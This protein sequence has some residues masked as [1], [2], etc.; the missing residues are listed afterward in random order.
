MSVF[1]SFFHNKKANG[2]K[3]IIHEIKKEIQCERL[4]KGKRQE[5]KKAIQLTNTSICI[6][7][8]R[9]FQVTQQCFDCMCN[10]SMWSKWV[11]S[12][13][14][15]QSERITMFTNVIRWN[16][17]SNYIFQHHH[18]KIVIRMKDVKWLRADTWRRKKFS[19]ARIS[20]IISITQCTHTVIQ[21]LCWCF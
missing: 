8:K 15:I 21:C 10:G 16:S 9:K 19:T 6:R 18:W 2:K 13:C 14:S 11:Y 5:K 7:K 1:F 20:K 12:V 17:S 3:R 4:K